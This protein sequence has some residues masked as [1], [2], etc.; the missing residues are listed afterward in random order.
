MFAFFSDQG[1]IL[2]KIVGI[3]LEEVF[4]WGPLEVAKYPVGLEQAA[5]D[6]PINE[7]VKQGELN[8]TMVVRIVGMSGAGKS[9]LAKYLY[10]LRRPNFN[11]RSC[12]LSEVRK[13]DLHW[14]QRKLLRDLIGYDQDFDI[15]KGKHILR[16]CRILLVLDDVDHM[17]QIDGLLDIDS[18][19]CG[20]LIFITSHE[21][22]LLRC[23]S[24]KTLL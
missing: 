13:K 1:E 16:H 12:F 8:Q 5:E 17:D 24:P 14:L 10:N 19:G 9:T 4:K 7:I 2:N 15:D 21:R 20:S 11:G 18:V 3:V 6:Y 23:P 22:E